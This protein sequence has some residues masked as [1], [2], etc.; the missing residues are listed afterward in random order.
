LVEQLKTGF[1]V[2]LPTT[3]ELLFVIEKFIAKGG[4]GEVYVAASAST[5]TRRA[6]KRVRYADRPEAERRKIEREHCQEAL[7]MLEFE[8]NHPN[9]V[10]LHF[11]LIAEKEFLMFQTLVE[12]ARGLDVAVRGELYSGTAREAQKRVVGVLSELAAAL[13]FCHASSILHQDVKPENVSQC[14]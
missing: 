2:R 12:G 9:L 7:L 8:R 5:G 13:A 3:G 11:C 1:E 4:F 14:V 10:G 6:M